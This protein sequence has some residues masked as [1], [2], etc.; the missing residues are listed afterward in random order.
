MEK[1][2]TALEL[3]RRAAQLIDLYRPGTWKT[4]GLIWT[5]GLLLITLVVVLALIGMYWSLEPSPLEL[6]AENGDEPLPQVIGYATTTALISAA[7][8]LLEK[9]GGYISNDVAPPGILLDNITRWEFGVLV[10]VRDLARAMRNDLSR[11]QSQS[12][13]DRDLIIAEPQFNFSNASWL[14][15]PTE[16]E[17]RTGIEA[18]KRYRDRLSDSNVHDAQFYAR[19]D[20]LRDWF[21]LVEKRLGSLS[22]R[23]TAS[24]GQPRLK[25]DLEVER[26][27]LQPTEQPDQLRV[28]TPWLKLDDIFYEAR[29]TSW[30]LIG[31]LKAIQIDFAEVLKKKNALV[32]LQQITRELEATQATVW[33]PIILNG[34][35]FAF[36]ANHSL[37]MA[38]YLARANAALIDLRQLLQQG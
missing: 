16:K 4:K 24:V 19:A 23:L 2:G 3:K 9:P 27:A 5:L 6:S 14:F 21:K 1:G 25:I 32:S 33:S 18:L 8:T 22:Q 30:A 10:Q 35:G 31:F 29:G 11:S 12:V 28:K 34:R 17:Y 7:E 38:S 36:V 13:E 20:N 26:A 37:V 15:P